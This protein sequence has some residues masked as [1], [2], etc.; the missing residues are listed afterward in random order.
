LRIEYKELSISGDGGGGGDFDDIPFEIDVYL[1]QID[2]GKIDAD[3][4]NTR[5]EKYL[6]SLKQENAERKQ[7]H[8]S[9]NELHKS[10]A[11]LSQE[12]QKYANI[13]LHD[14]QSGEAR[15]DK[16][17]TFREHIVDYQSKAKHSE[18]DTFSAVLG[19]DKSK[20]IAMLNTDITLLNINEYGRFDDLKQSV[21]KKKS[22]AYF[23]ELEGIRIPMR[24]VNM[25][26]YNLLQDFI[27][28]AVSPF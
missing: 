18:I 9:L 5:F 6:K 12:E 1:T 19:L 15:F 25:K 16:E 8:N 2:T 27:I 24:K 3:Y 22:Q 7:V 13:F 10:F 20:L 17:K 23:E 11:S 26:V 28:K 4:M 21:D 14:V